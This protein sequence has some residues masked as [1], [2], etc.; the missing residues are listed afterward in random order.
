MRILLIDDSQT[1]LKLATRFLVE[2][3][4]DDVTIEQATDCETALAVTKCP[5]IILLDLIMPKLSGLD[6]IP[7]FRARLPQARIIVLS[8]SDPLVYQ[9]AALDAGADAFISKTSIGSS[10]LPAIHKL[11]A[12]PVEILQEGL[13]C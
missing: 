11:V 2:S 10:L 7:L 12:S 4:R 8:L 13:S 6:A 1:F 9:T 5:D 3:L